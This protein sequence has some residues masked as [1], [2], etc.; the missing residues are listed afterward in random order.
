[1]CSKRK[2]TDLDLRDADEVEIIKSL[3]ANC[4]RKYV[5][6]K[7][8][9]D[10]ST[11]SKLLTNSDIVMKDFHSSLSATSCKRMRTSV[12]SGSGVEQAK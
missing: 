3:D 11:L 5:A 1:M 12:Y 10:V 8:G 7:Y 9:V 6:E 4:K 2:R